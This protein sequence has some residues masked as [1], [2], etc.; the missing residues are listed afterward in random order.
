MKKVTVLVL[1]AALAVFVGSWAGPVDTAYAAGHGG[2]RGG[3]GWHGGGHGGGNFNVWFGPGWGWDP[4]FYPYYPYYPS[5]PAYQPPVVIQQ[6]EQY[7]VPEPQP[8]QT[9][10]WYYCQN[11]KGYYPYVKRCPGGWMKVVPSP[12]PPGEG[13]DEGE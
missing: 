12:G 8:Q 11:P 9:S 3:G 2:G 5:Y 10:Y 13:P 4:F 6:P 1:A 7:V